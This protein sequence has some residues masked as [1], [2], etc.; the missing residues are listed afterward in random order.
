MLPLLPAGRHCRWVYTVVTTLVI[1]SGG[2]Q[3]ALAAIHRYDAVSLYQEGDAFISQG[4]RE[5]MFE[6]EAK[7]HV[8]K[9]ISNGQSYIKFNSVDIK[10]AE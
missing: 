9:G 8:N 1:A 10:L 4:G 3:L 7:T 6:S 5:G 2:L